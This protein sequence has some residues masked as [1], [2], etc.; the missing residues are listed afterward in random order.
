MYIIGLCQ[1]T[2][3]SDSLLNRNR[4]MEYRYAD[5]E[6][7]WQKKWIED[8]VFETKDDDTKDKFYCLEMFPYPSGK[9]H[10]GHVRN[11]S[12]GDVLARLKRRQG[13]SVL[14]PM[15]Y[16]SFGLPAENA[17]IKRRSH[18][19]EWTYTCIDMMKEQQDRMG[20]SYDWNRKVVTC[21]PDY[22]RWN[23]WIFLQF[24]K[25]GLAYRKKSAH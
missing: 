25:H 16:D 13:Y 21:S 22:F 8:G 2:N 12:I 15:G 6:D 23:Q 9:L 18:P 14:Y 11:Y 3:Y 24:L 5:I 20:F 17:A 7:K 4:T 19:K 10:M 1:A